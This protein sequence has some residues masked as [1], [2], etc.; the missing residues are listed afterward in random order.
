MR[1]RIESEPPANGPLLGTH[2]RD[3]KL[4][5]EEGGGSGRN[6]SGLGAGC[7][8]HT[9]TRAPCRVYAAPIHVS[10]R[11]PLLFKYLF[12]SSHL[13]VPCRHSS[14][15]LGSIFARTNAKLHPDFGAL[16]QPTAQRFE[17]PP[18]LLP[19]R[20]FLSPPCPS[21]LLWP[22]SS[23]SPLPSRPISAS[24]L[25]GLCRATP[26]PSHH[27]SCVFALCECRRP[28]ALRFFLVRL[29]VIALVLFHGTHCVVFSL[30]FLLARSSS[31]ELLILC[32]ISSFLLSHTHTPTHTPHA[33]RRSSSPRCVLVCLSV[34]CV[35]S[36]YEGDNKGA[37]VWGLVLACASTSPGLP[38]RFPWP[39]DPVD[40]VHGLFPN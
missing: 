15:R 39:G 2:L 17:R 6:G 25:H 30:P 33:H 40:L 19:S 10:L 26:L 12:C 1:R 37:C 8:P 36:P 11:L 5:G 3:G 4:H 18:P 9:H 28:A 20:P 32:C 23:L 27:L 31:C 22:P 35:A 14:W 38:P 34:Y 21:I 13:R 16:R 29:C 24:S 7:A